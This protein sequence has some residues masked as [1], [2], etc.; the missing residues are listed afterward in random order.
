MYKIYQLIYFF[1]TGLEV[2]FGNFSALSWDV[3]E[4]LVRTNEVAIHYPSSLQILKVPFSTIYCN[5]I[6]RTDG[7]SKMSLSSLVAHGIR[8]MVVL[9]EIVSIRIVTICLIGV[10]LCLA[11]LCLVFFIKFFTNLAIPGWATSAFGLLSIMCIQLLLLA[12][13]FLFLVFQQKF[14]SRG[15]LFIDQEVRTVNRI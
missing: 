1:L 15:K 6:E 10:G 14:F 12:S 2:N 3:V 13:C 7:R 9:C 5:R 8:S 11:S 4:R